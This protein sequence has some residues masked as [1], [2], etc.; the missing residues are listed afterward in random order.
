[1]IGPTEKAL[2]ELMYNDQARCLK[3]RMKMAHTHKECMHTLRVA[4]E[5]MHGSGVESL[6]PDY[7]DFHYVNL[8]ETYKTTLCYDGK[9]FFIGSWGD[10][11]E[12]K[13]LM[14]TKSN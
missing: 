14:K 2:Q 1:M 6:Y 10:W 3:A 4:D 5:F 11:V 8:G 13:D 9:K 7:P 12:G